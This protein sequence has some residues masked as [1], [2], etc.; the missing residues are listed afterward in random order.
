[1]RSIKA[2][3]PDNPQLKVCG[4]LISRGQWNQI[5]DEIN[6]EQIFANAISQKRDELEARKNLSRSMKDTWP[7]TVV[8]SFLI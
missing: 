7:N 3:D 2:R 5:N 6:H 1:M 4:L 8:V